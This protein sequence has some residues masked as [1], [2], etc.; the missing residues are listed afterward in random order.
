MRNVTALL[1]F[2]VT[3]PS[4]ARFILTRENERNTDEGKVTRDL[5]KGEGIEVAPPGV[6]P[7]AG[8]VQ[9]SSEEPFEPGRWGTFTWGPLE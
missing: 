7:D 4:D 2:P 1:Y 8:D 9:I 3:L 5:A 6:Q